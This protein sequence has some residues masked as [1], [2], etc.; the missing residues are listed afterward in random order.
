MNEV[1]VVPVQ[2]EN[3]VW[4][5]PRVTRP[6][7][8]KK[9]AAVNYMSEWGPSSAPGA[10]AGVGERRGAA[11]WGGLRVGKQQGHRRGVPLAAGGAVAANS[12]L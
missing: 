3:H 12:W 8:P 10:S 1:E 11:G 5:Q 4:V 2:E 7:K 9:E 6:T